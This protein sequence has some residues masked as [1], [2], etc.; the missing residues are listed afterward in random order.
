VSNQSNRTT[1]DQ[2]GVYAAM[3]QRGA[4]DFRL[5]K[6]LNDNPYR[7]QPYRRAWADGYYRELIDA[8]ER[9][10]AA[11]ARL[12]NTSRF[13]APVERLGWNAGGLV[14]WGTKNVSIVASNN[15][16][17]LPNAT[18][19]GWNQARFHYCPSG[20]WDEWVALARNILAIN[21][22]PTDGGITSGEA[23]NNEEAVVPK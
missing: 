18:F 11:V 15:F 13:T 21:A 19:Q 4:S 17:A 20:T 3:F 16:C 1:G 23:Q 9:A 12:P 6:A 7:R 5:G 10:T 14:I 8:S 22:T 2:S